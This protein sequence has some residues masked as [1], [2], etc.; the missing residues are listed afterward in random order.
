MLALPQAI[1]HNHAIDRRRFLTASTATAV[2][3]SAWAHPHHQTKTGNANPQPRVVKVILQGGP[4]QIDL[5]DMKPNARSD[6]RGSF[7]PIRTNVTGIQI[8][9]ILPCIATMMDQFTIVRSI[10]GS[11]GS[12]N[13]IQ[14]ETG[15]PAD[16]RHPSQQRN[17]SNAAQLASPRYASTFSHVKSLLQDGHANIVLRFGHW[18][19]HQQ[20]APAIKQI[21]GQFDQQFVRLIG[22]LSN[23]GLLEQTTILVWAEFGRSPYINAAGGR[24]HWPAINSAFIAGGPVSRG[25][26]WGATSADG[27]HITDAPIRM[28]ELLQQCHQSATA[29]LT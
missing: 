24:D 26:V 20:L 4:S 18:D 17:H 14:A 9:E 5:W 2:C 22:S 29:C 6:I 10:T 21:A 3:S 23:T 15:F 19:H 28:N 16:V 8:S 13:L 11:A 25:N 7:Q 1:E 12:H 27:S